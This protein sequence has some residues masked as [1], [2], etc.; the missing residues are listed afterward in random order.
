M[1]YITDLR[2]PS[3][4][5]LTLSPKCMATGSSFTLLTQDTSQN[6]FYTNNGLDIII[7]HTN[8]TP[9]LSEAKIIANYNNFTKK[10]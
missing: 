5:K 7:P 3:K 2:L 8:V 9:S 10:S 1:T 6:N 4:G